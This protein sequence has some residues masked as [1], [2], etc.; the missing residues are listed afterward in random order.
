M[1]DTLTYTS[2][3]VVLTCWCGMPHAVPGELRRHQMRQHENGQDVVSIYCPLGH[4]HVPSGKSKI[5][6]VR[7]QREAAKARAQA[8]QDQLDSEKRAHAATKGTLTK[9]K[10]RVTNGVCPCCNR[11]F[12]NVERHMKTK[13]PN[14]VVAAP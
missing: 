2:E 1:T 11:H 9:T 3:L 10:R 8:I 13:H 14:E 6:T 7:E 12:V 5:D 4:G